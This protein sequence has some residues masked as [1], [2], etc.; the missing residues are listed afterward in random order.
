MFYPRYYPWLLRYPLAPPLVALALGIGLG[1]HLGD[2]YYRA[3][4]W[5][6]AGSLLLW[7]FLSSGVPKW[8]HKK[9]ACLFKDL[10]G[11]L[12]MALLG[13][14]YFHYR[15]P[16]HDARHF[17]Q[18][19]GAIEGYR[20]IAVDEVTRKRRFYS[21]TLAVQQVRIGGTWHQAH[22]KVK[23]SGF[24][25][26]KNIA[27][28]DRVEVAGKPERVPAR[29]NPYTFNGRLFLAAKDIHYSHHLGKK[30]FVRHRS[31]PPEG[32]LYHRHKVRQWGARQLTRYCQ[33]S[34]AQGVLLAMI[35]GKRSTL[36]PFLKEMYTHAGVM[37]LLAI[38]G[39]HVGLVYMLL[40]WLFYLLGLLA[41]R[42]KIHS[43][44]I[45]LGLWGYAWLTGLAPSVLRAV[46]MC[47]LV[48]L[49]RELR[50]SIVMGNVLAGAAFLLLLYRPY[51]LF[52]VGFQFSFGAVWGIFSFYQALARWGA[53]EDCFMQGGWKMLSVCMAAQL[54]TFPLA[55][56]YFHCFPTYFLLGN[57][58]ML[59][60]A[61]FLLMAGVG[62]LLFSPLPGVSEGLGWLVGYVLGKAHGVLRNIL[63]LPYARLEDCYTP[64]GYVVLLYVALM[65]CAVDIWQGRR[66]YSWGGAALCVGLLGWS[67]YSHY[68]KECQEKIIFY[69]VAPAQ[70]IAFV[71]G[72]K[73]LILS[74]GRLAPQDFIYATEMAPSL[75]AM[76]V[77]TLKWCRW[78]HM[79]KCPALAYEDDGAVRVVSW[80]EKKIAFVDEGV[81]PEEL[82]VDILVTPGEHL[83]E[84]REKGSTWKVR[85]LIVVGQVAGK[86][87]ID[88]QTYFLSEQGAYLVS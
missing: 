16:A 38:S 42:R 73:A 54:G 80:R 45:L 52:S 86:E 12:F 35:L 81:L 64:L 2:V 46:G 53:Q 11:M 57:G 76:G 17:A 33:D 49:A 24:G 1:H 48:H 67:G 72:R 59:P 32:W 74:V 28:G 87:L 65:S 20:G 69:N 61:T 83:R 37:H 4:S 10:V 27:Y 31:A 18:K 39:L 60:L 15:T 36:E 66:R 62:I 85:H 79:D 55:L 21:T 47:T 75:R 77:E 88:E 5:L 82:E 22:G 26:G 3:S 34:D 9:Q 50:R 13:Y 51:F 19:I 8:R 71:A 44:L 68:E 40:L 43:L 7:L 70:G 78:A 41:G 84:V 29:R 14:T 58:I 25:K 63:A 56:Y 23:V 6:A 30:G